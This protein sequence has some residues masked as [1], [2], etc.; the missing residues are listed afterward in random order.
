M[1]LHQAVRNAV[2]DRFVVHVA[3]VVAVLNDVLVQN[4]IAEALAVAANVFFVLL[5][6]LIPYGLLAICLRN[7][8]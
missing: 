3:V 8:N 2:R 1:V 7:A 4:V 5:E 6:I